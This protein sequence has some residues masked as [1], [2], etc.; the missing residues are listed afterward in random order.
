MT[1]CC[2]GD[3]SNQRE[4]TLLWIVLVLNLVM[5]FVEF[6]AG[7]IADSSGLLADSLDMLADAAV[8]AVS[9]Y[10]VGRAL[11]HRA[12]AALL[13]GSLQMLLGVGVVVEVVRRI[14]FGS[15]P[16]AMTMTSIALLALST[17]HI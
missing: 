10:A 7:W 4:R 14:V 9:L 3:A 6:T 11:K 15:A 1:D 8:Y 5:F 2:G 13:N 16:E 12:Q 17:R